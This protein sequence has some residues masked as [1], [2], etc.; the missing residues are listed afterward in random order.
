MSDKDELERQRFE[1]WIQE[2]WSQTKGNLVFTE[3]GYGNHFVN[4]AWE[5]WKARSKQGVEIEMPPTVI[6]AEIGPAISHEKMMARLAVI[7]IKVK[8]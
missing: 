8:T 4:Y 6:T 2:W 7:G 5:G 3:D 1:A